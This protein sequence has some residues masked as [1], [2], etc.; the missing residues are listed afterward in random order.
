MNK[1]W[2]F[3]VLENKCIHKQ[4]YTLM[5]KVVYIRQEFVGVA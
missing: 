4:L 5:N 3:I 1:L 2:I